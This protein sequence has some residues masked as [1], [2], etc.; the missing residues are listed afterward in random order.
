MNST[1]KENII[2][3]VAGGIKKRKVNNNTYKIIEKNMLN[4]G[5]ILQMLHD[6]RRGRGACHSCLALGPSEPADEVLAFVRD[7]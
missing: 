7:G 3:L 5:W 1:Y 4:A 6:F 2:W